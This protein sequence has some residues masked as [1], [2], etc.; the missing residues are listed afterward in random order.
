M[1]VVENQVELQS[2]LGN[3]PDVNCRWQDCGCGTQHCLVPCIGCAIISLM[4]AKLL[5]ES[6][7]KLN[8][9][10]FYQLPDRETQ[11]C[12]EVHN[13]RAECLLVVFLVVAK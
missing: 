5:V 4:T 6:D 10:P 2:K 12:A 7:Q 3:Q 8:N 13:G 11:G 9:Q 1:T